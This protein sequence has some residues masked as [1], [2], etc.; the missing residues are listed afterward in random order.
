MTYYKNTL[1]ECYGFFTD[2][3]NIPNIGA[4]YN[5]DENRMYY[6]DIP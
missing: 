5:A 2:G 3:V 1:L 6:V 4:H